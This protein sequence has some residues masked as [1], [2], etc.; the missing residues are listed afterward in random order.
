MTQ[1]PKHSSQK[2]VLIFFVLAYAITWGL[3]ALATQQILPWDVPPFLMTASSI[4]LHYGPALA[5]IIMVSMEGG[6]SAVGA[7][8]GR[9]GQWRV[10]VRWYLFVFLF[11]LLVR[12]AAVGVD[13]LLGGQF[14]PFFSAGIVPEGN[15]LLLLPVVFLAVFFQAGL[16][17][18]IGWRG[19]ALP[20]LQQRYGALT[21]SLILGVIWTFWHYH[22]ENF[23]DIWPITGYYLFSVVGLTILMT[24]IQNN[25]RASLLLAVLFHTVSNV[26]DWI[27]PTFP[28]VASANGMRPF[29]IEGLLT[30]VT[31]LVIIATSGAKYLR[32]QNSVV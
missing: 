15:P 18:E 8:L 20:R 17:E 19:Y 2:S 21:S 26:S 29:L 30:W 25:T 31:V 7:L 28:L 9:L 6:R 32:R 12:L 4:L 22:P 10:G 27:I 14:P 11:P 1:H 13:V 3:S 16:A 24:W 5:A 23:A